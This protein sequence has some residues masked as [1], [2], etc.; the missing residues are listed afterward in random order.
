MKFFAFE[1][2]LLVIVGV[3]GRLRFQL[4]LQLEWQSELQPQQR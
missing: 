2:E 1:R 4:E 3:V